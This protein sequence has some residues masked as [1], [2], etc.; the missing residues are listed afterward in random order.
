MKSEEIFREMDMNYE[1]LSAYLQEKYGKAK[2][3]YFANEKCKSSNSRKNSRTKEGLI[4]HHI[5]EDKAV[6]LSEGKCAAEYQRAHRLTYCNYLEHLLLHILIAKKMYRE[7]CIEMNKQGKSQC[8][9]FITPGIQ[10]ICW[11]INEM[12]FKKE[13]QLE[14]RIRCFEEIEDNFDDYIYILR[15]FID[16]IKNECDGK[17]D[18]KEEILYRIKKTISSIRGSGY[19][20]MIYERI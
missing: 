10:F 7:K 1:Q 20:E 15:S 12:F 11:D 3:D 18:E 2:Y 13:S 19:I 8:V 17:I 14:W 6:C 5:D 9:S 16:Y 4:L